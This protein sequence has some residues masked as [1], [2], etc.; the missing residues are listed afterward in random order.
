VAVFAEQFGDGRAPAPAAKYRY[1]H[2]ISSS[3]L[4]ANHSAQKNAPFSCPRILRAGGLAASFGI[5]DPRPVYLRSFAPEAE[6]RLRA[7]EKPFDI[8]PVP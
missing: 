5:P 8:F 6:F 1:L 4:L 2:A 7:F 3:D